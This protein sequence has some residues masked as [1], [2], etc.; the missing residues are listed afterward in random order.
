M[1]RNTRRPVGNVRS[2]NKL[3]PK[4]RPQK[5]IDATVRTRNHN[6]ETNNPERI[7]NPRTRDV[8]PIAP[9]VPTPLRTPKRGFVSSGAGVEGQD[10]GL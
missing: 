8:T 5:R 4:K 10:V 2:R 6:Y 3:L 1:C 9:E 7:Q